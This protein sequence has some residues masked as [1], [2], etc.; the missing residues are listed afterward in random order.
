MPLSHHTA[1]LFCTPCVCSFCWDHRLFSHCRDT[2]GLALL[3][4]L[5]GLQKLRLDPKVPTVW[6]CFLWTDRVSVLAFLSPG[7]G[8]LVEDI[9]VRKAG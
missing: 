1:L 2:C 5:L 7:E 8:F 4:T 6:G 9:P 3:T